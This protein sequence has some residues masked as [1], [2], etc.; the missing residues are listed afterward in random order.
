MAE[1][2]T[3]EAAASTSP[4][5][6]T[7]PPPPGS[8]EEMSAILRANLRDASGVTADGIPAGSAEVDPASVDPTRIIGSPEWLI[9]KQEARGIKMT[10]AEAK[11]S[12]DRGYTIGSWA[13]LPNY[14][15]VLCPNVP[16]QHGV[17]TPATAS[18]DLEWLL[19]NHI[20]VEHAQGM[21]LSEGTNYLYD[22]R[23]R[24]FEVQRR[25]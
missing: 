25:R 5:P 16:N 1:K 13:G 15:C 4:S 17:P 8:P 21:P 12:L 23:G 14:E 24:L 22:S 3:E 18:I 9:A 6:P 19:E 2:K 11:E 20:E 10:K 7:P